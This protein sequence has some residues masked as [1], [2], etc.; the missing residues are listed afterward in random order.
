MERRAD[1]FHDRLKEAGVDIYLLVKYVDDCILAKSII[2]MGYKW[3]KTTEGGMLVW[4]L[5]WLE[6]QEIEDRRIG[7]MDQRRTMNLLVEAANSIIKGIKFTSDTPELHGN[8]MCPMLDNEVWVDRQGQGQ[9]G[10][11]EGCSMRH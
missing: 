2:K 3:L 7:E 1:S 11:E 4:R 6:E 9:A 10:Q 5:V 8:S